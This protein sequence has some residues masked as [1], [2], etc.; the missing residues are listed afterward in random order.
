[1][2]WSGFWTTSLVW[3]WLPGESGVRPKQASSAWPRQRAPG[4]RTWLPGACTGDAFRLV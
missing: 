4:A 1:M 3:C 2:I